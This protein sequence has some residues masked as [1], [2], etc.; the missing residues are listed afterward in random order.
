MSNAADRLD[1]C[2]FLARKPTAIRLTRR[3]R[4]ELYQDL[5]PHRVAD[6]LLSTSGNDRYKG[7]P[8]HNIAGSGISGVDGVDREGNAVFI[9]LRR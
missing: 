6:L 3:S 7:V 2:L 4:A 5:E 1:E 8:I 9:P